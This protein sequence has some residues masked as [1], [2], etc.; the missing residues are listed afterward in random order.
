MEDNNVNGI[1]DH[2]NCVSLQAYKKEK[3]ELTANLTAASS[4]E[5]K[6]K[7]ENI[8]LQNLVEELKDKNKK[9]TEEMKNKENTLTCSKGDANRLKL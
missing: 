4:K 8:R 2:S 9:L 1:V 5:W 7:L 6:T 3:A